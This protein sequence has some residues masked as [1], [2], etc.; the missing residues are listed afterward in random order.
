MKLLV[1]VKLKALFH[2]YNLIFLPTNI[3]PK[4]RIFL[5]ETLDDFD[6]NTHNKGILAH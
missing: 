6:F 3:I 2:T 5:H 4:E 1:G